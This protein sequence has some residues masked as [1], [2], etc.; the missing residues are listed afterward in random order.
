M[1]NLS[2]HSVFSWNADVYWPCRTVQMRRKTNDMYFSFFLSHISNQDRARARG[3]VQFFCQ[4]RRIIWVFFSLTS[5]YT[6]F[7]FSRSFV[8]QRKRRKKEN[9]TVSAKHCRVFPTFVKQK[10]IN[11]IHPF[12][13]YGRNGKIKE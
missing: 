7:S 12:T 11:K 10:D 1:T 3:N 8:F 5:L 4:Y 9:R 13:M 6:T 2:H